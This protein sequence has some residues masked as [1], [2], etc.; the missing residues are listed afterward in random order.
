MAEQDLDVPSSAAE[1]KKPRAP[2]S[3]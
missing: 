3:G 1:Q 2:R